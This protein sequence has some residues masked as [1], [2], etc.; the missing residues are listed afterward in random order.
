MSP[1]RIAIAAISMIVLVGVVTG[2]VTGAVGSLARTG[3]YA[4]GLWSTNGPSTLPSG[5]DP[6]AHEQ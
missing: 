5:L 4:T 3:L 6:S 2:I 1:K